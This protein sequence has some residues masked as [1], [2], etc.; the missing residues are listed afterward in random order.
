MNN[1]P[2]VPFSVS[3]WVHILNGISVICIIGS[4]I[5]VISEY[6][7]LPDTIPIHFNALGEADNWGS[8]TT[9]FISPGIGILIFIALYF[10]SKYPHVFNYPF[11]ITEENASRIYPVANLFMTIIN[12]EMVLIFTFVS[13]DIFSDFLGLWFIFV[14]FGLPLLTILIFILQI[15]KVA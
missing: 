9:V 13:I 8:K 3:K 15:R 11:P 1:H 5:Y 2:K 7:H 4:V 6:Q 12:L 14:V 10:V